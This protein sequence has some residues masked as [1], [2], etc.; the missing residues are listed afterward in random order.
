MVVGSAA[1]GPQEGAVES[2]LGLCEAPRFLSPSPASQACS[3]HLT[4]APQPHTE[5]RPFQVA[6][7]ARVLWPPSQI[8]IDPQ[9]EGL[10]EGPPIFRRQAGLA[11]SDL[12]IH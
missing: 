5:R 3:P 4:L 7:P 12:I 8:P 2:E 11:A 6:L 9:F 1:C 10:E